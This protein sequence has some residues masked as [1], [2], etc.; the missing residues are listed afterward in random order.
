MKSEEEIDWNSMIETEKYLNKRILCL[1]NDAD[2]ITK[3]TE[4]NNIRA[5]ELF[6]NFLEQ[7]NNIKKIVEKLKIDMKD[8]LI[9]M[10]VLI[11]KIKRSAK[12][13]EVNNI[14]R[15]IE[16]FNP[17]GLITKYELHKLID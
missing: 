12:N 11:D 2:H 16:D 14:S 8:C 17:E 5:K 3:I 10:D 7:I 13:D 4:A 9:E 6:E 15:R 1:E